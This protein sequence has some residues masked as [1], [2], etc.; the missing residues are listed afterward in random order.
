[1][2]LWD[3]TFSSPLRYLFA[4]YPHL[5]SPVLQVVKRASKDLNFID[6]TQEK[7]HVTFYDRDS[8]ETR[9]GA[10]SE[11]ALITFYMAVQYEVNGEYDP[12]LID[13]A[14]TSDT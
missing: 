4:N 5:F 1:M 13:F 12:Q 7:A 10:K 11:V 8:W 6:A 3:V 9:D 14:G 2:C